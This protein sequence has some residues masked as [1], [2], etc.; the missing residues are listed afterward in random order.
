M[1]IRDSAK[2]NNAKGKKKRP[3]VANDDSG[4]VMQKSKGG[5]KS[6]WCFI[7]EDQGF[8]SCMPVT[9]SEKCMSGDIFSSKKLCE[10]PSLR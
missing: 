4:S 8:R 9:E 7:G 5:N 3:Q 10:N 2:G 1:C 6:G